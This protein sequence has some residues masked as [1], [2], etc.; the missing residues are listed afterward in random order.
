MTPSLAQHAALGRAAVDSDRAFESAVRQH[1]AMVFSVAYHFLQDH[2]AAEEVA[3]EVFLELYRHWHELGSDE[4]RLHW[5]RKVASRRSIDQGRRR[6][7][8]RHVSLDDA[9]EPFSWM[10]ATDPVVKRYIEQLL[11]KL[12]EAPRLIV[13]LRYQEGLEP[14]EIASLLDMP[15]A[16]VKSH[17]HRSLAAL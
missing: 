15:L 13:I 5:L 14:A 16:T 8:R 4:H 6:K 3:Q 11:A 1:Q 2:A 9:P 10:P 7:L 12:P 17:L